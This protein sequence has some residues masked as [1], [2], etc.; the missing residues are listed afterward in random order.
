MYLPPQLE[1]LAEQCRE[2]SGE[3]SAILGHADAHGD[4]GPGYVNDFIHGDL[5]M[6]TL[7]YFRRIENNCAQGD[8][9]EGVCGSIRKDQLK[10]LGIYFD[11]GVQNAI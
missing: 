4:D 8:Q 10:Q 11:K 5:F 3:E 2:E 1:A 9:L 7:S 6:N